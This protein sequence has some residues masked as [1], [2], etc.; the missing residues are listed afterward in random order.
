MKVNT[1]KSF[2]ESVYYLERLKVKYLKNKLGFGF[3]H[4]FTKEPT[5]FRLRCKNDI[6]DARKI[7]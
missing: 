5:L 4:E 7:T 1:K 2:N 3:K 6:H